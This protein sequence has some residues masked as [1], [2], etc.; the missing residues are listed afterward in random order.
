MALVSAALQA[1]F[2]D[3]MNNKG[4]TAA[5]CAALWAT[6]FG[7]YAA[8]VVPPSVTVPAAQATLQSALASA[9]ASPSAMAAMDAAFTAAAV[10]IGA[11]MAPA[12][13]AVPPP[14]PI[15]WATVLAAPYAATNG[16][17]ATKIANAIHA[18][19]LTGLATPVPPGPPVPWS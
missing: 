1:S 9:F 17:A 15:G 8:S 11:G 14:A 12:F 3:L 13:I 6:A 19:M 7:S 5:A 16:A 18:W 4:A 2:L 10:T